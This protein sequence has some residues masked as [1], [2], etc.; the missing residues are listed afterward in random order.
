MSSMGETGLLEI[1]AISCSWIISESFIT[2]IGISDNFWM[3][4]MLSLSLIKNSEFLLDET[5]AAFLLSNDFSAC[6]I[7]L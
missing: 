3:L 1:C 2:L 6:E 4:L 7:S 5:P